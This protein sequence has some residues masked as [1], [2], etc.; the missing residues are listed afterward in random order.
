M[1]DMQQ[2][3]KE[4]TDYIVVF[5]SILFLRT[6]TRFLQR[7]STHNQY[8]NKPKIT[9]R[10]LFK[11]GLINLKAI[12]YFH[13]DSSSLENTR[14]ASSSQ[15]RRSHAQV[16]F[17]SLNIISCRRR[18]E[19]KLLDLNMSLSAKNSEL[20]KQ[21][22]SIKLECSMS[23]ISSAVN[24]ILCIRPSNQR[25]KFSP[26]SFSTTNGCVTASS[27]SNPSAVSVLFSSSSFLQESTLYKWLLLDTLRVNFP[28]AELPIELHDRIYTETQS[29]TAQ[30]NATTTQLQQLH[31]D[32]DTYKRK[33]R[34][35]TLKLQQF[36]TQGKSSQVESE[37]RQQI[38]ALEDE[39]QELRRS[40]S[41]FQSQLEALESVRKASGRLKGANEEQNKTRR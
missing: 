41:S 30:L 37:L 22:A 29:L 18:N 8:E 39:T 17:I 32:F 16:L 26:S 21:I 27:K 6:K 5:V 15:E 23:F 25:S 19:T 34:A 14:P 40:N 31:E 4:K 11:P 10:S 24:C 35:A 2:E 36:V 7:I 13:S 28:N 20:E 33:T 12:K 9:S 38:K 1:V 3:L